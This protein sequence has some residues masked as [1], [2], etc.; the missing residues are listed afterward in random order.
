M[1]KDWLEIRSQFPVFKNYVYLDQLIKLHYHFVT[2][3]I[4]QFLENQQMT[5]GDKSC[6]NYEV[7][8]T[9]EKI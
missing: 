6:W 1:E 8:K 3:A 7:N 2:R 5:G 4:Q 9:R